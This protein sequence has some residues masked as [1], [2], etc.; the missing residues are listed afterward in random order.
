MKTIREMRGSI[1]AAQENN[2]FTKGKIGINS[3]R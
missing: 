1:A 2:G 3:K